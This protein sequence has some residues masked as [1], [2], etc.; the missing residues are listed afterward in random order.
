M[1]GKNTIEIQIQQQLNTCFVIMPFDALFQ[2]QYEN[3]IKPSIESLGIKCIRGNEIYSRQN[4]MSDIWKSIRECRFI[5]AEL[6]ERNPNVMYEIGLA[7]AIGK[8]TILLTRN[9]EDVPFDLKGIRYRFYDV[10]DP[11]W[12]TNLSEAIKDMVKKILNEEKP[13]KYLDG[14]EVKID[15]A[16]VPVFQK[17]EFT[18]K[19]KAINIAGTW[20]G[21]W[22][23]SNGIIPHLGIILINQKEEQLSCHMT[24]TLGIDEEYTIVQETLTGSINSRSIILSGISYTYIHQGA[25]TS[26]FLDS[27][28]LE[29]SKD[30][31]QLIGVF[32]NKAGVGNA[33]FKRE[34]NNQI[35]KI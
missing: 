31:N 7:H 17:E 21:E 23:R 26:Y 25:S 20:T 35:R 3:V 18:L 15:V 24:V 11:F 34:I 29:L 32:K 27:F 10:N 4:I 19:S 30:D 16:P 1:A 33:F 8:P 12:G 14:I 2:S 9:E 22:M 5:L 28:E 6:T 13:E